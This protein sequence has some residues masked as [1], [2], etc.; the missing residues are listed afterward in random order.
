MPSEAPA[1]PPSPVSAHL[2]AL[3][4]YM[5]LAGAIMTV[6]AVSGVIP[7][8]PWDKLVMGLAS[9]FSTGGGL[10]GVMWQSPNVRAILEEARPT[11][12]GVAPPAE[13]K[14]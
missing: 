7:D 9:L 2:F 14:P 12:A 11:P 8:G 3:H 4:T 5:L 10:S 6:V 13:V 1:I